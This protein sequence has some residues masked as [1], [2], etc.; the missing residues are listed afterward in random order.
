[1]VKREAS[2]ES[3]S[4]PLR[5]TPYPLRSQAL[6]HCLSP[7][8]LLHSFLMAMQFQKIDPRVTITTPFGEIKIRF[9][10]DDAP[11]HVEN[12][13]KLAKMGFYDGT[14]FHR[15]VP[16]FIIQ[17]GDPL[18]KNSDRSLHGSGS[19]GYWLNPETSDRPHK[20]GAVAM[21]KVP[22]ESNSTRDP[23]DNG[24]QFYICVADSSG[25]DRT[26]TVFGEVVRG[27]EV[28]DKI[29]AAARDEFDNPLEPIEIKMTVKE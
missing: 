12:F 11:R 29:V 7:L 21:A 13:I 5:L 9:Y 6:A 25:L 10:P 20:R 19:P 1:M 16:G 2:G 28:V 26:Y 18:S 22:R 27:M 4:T 15:V 14:T 24:S 3:R 23:N 8:A 17:G